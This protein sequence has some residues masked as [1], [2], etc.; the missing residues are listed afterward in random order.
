ML[1]VLLAILL[2]TSLGWAANQTCPSGTLSSGDTVTA[3]NATA[4]AFQGVQLTS[5]PTVAIQIC[6]VGTCDQTT[7]SWAPITGGSMALSAGTPTLAISVIY[8]TCIY[9]AAITGGTATVGFACSG[10]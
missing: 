7:G 5:S 10:P 2:S 3:R 1:R 8:P 9:R 6:C 4:L